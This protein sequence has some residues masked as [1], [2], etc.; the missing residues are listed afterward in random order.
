MILR[1]SDR[2]DPG[3]RPGISPIRPHRRS[4]IRANPRFER[5]SLSCS[6][7][8]VRKVL[9]RHGL[10]PA[11]LVTGQPE[12]DL[13]RVGQPTPLQECAFQLLGIKIRVA[14]TPAD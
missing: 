7:L 8:T 11:L 5:H 14:K 13:E 10:P 6:Y 3:G 1:H 4:P 12:R 2:A 9:R